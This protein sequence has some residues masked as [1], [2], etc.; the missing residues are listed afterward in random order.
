MNTSTFRGL[1]VFA[2]LAGASLSLAASVTQSVAF[3]ASGI[4]GTS[5]T[6]R[7]FENGVFEKFDP[8]LGLLRSVS[9]TVSTTGHAS[10]TDAHTFS[11]VRVPIGFSPL[12]AVQCAIESTLWDPGFLYSDRPTYEKTAADPATIAYGK[13]V[14]YGFDFNQSVSGTTST[15]LG[16]FQGAGE[17]AV[18]VGVQ[19]QSGSSTVFSSLSHTTV[20]T[21]T[22][23]YSEAGP[24]RRFISAP[25][26][27]PD[28]GMS[29][30][31]LAFSFGLLVA[32]Y[33][34]LNQ[35]LSPICHE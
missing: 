23:D 8:S 28:G 7:S 5:G 12:L 35:N 22:Y 4:T 6:V 1:S 27:V 13:S 16:A 33:R 20:A 32:L 11:M 10:A 30:C 19:L 9:I 29:A 21:L 17:F 3:S 26:S 34:R 31:L 24:A 14:T 25:V 15:N 18:P 2:F